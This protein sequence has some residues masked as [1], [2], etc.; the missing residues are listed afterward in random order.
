M[1]LSRKQT[2]LRTAVSRSCGQRPERVIPACGIASANHY[3][4]AG[5]RHLSGPRA[6]PCCSRP[7][8]PTWVPQGPLGRRMGRLGW[9]HMRGAWVCLPTRQPRTSLCGHHRHVC[10]PFSPHTRPHGE[11][12]TPPW[13]LHRR[14]HGGVRRDSFR[15]ELPVSRA[16]KRGNCSKEGRALSAALPPTPRH[17]A[18]SHHVCTRV[19]V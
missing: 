17:P 10:C 16:P 1:R 13:S 8:R 9:A 11:R 12:S 3:E 18:P 14:Q 19:C 2:T 5:L 7:P 15:G 4:N 6:A